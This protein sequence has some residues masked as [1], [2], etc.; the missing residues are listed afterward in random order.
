M[1]LY[2]PSAAAKVI[3]LLEVGK[4]DTSDN[5]RPASLT[6]DGKY[7]EV[8]HRVP[9]GTPLTGPTGVAAWIAGNIATNELTAWALQAAGQATARGSALPQ[10]SVREGWTPLVLN[11]RDLS[12]E[13]RALFRLLLAEINAVRTAAALPAR[14]EAELLTAFKAQREVA[15]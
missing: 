9:G 12:P 15:P 8:H 5:T 13:S 10:R 3:V 6:L 1:A 2:I 4:V 14:T 11:I 7:W